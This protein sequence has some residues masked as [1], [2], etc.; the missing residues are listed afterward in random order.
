M[1]QQWK[2]SIIVLVYKQGDKIDFSNYRGLLLLS[3]TYKIVSNILVWRLTPHVDE[4]MG[5]ISVDF[6]VVGQLLIRYSA[7][8]RYWRKNG[9]II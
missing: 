5:V 8:V 4:L 2:E 3:T 9:S 1:T 7:F 6:D